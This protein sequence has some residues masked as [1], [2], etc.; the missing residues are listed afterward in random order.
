MPGLQQPLGLQFVDDHLA[1]L[2][3]V[4]AFDFSHDLSD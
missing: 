4:S 2:A 3:G 1:N